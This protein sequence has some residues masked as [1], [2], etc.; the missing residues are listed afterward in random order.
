MR[1]VATIE[2]AADVATAASER[3]VL[4]DGTVA[5]VRALQRGE[6]PPITAWFDGLGLETRYARFLGTVDALA[7][8]LLASLADVD[9]CDHEALVAIGPDD[10]TMGIARYIR[11]RNPQQAEVAV[12]V[13]DR[14][15]NRGVAGTLL[16]QLADRAR[17]AGIHRLSATCLATNHAVIRTLS[18]VG[19][20]TT[21]PPLGGVVEVWIDLDRPTA[22][23]PS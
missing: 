17:A 15:R 8:D 22:N 21:G 1:P 4:R 7:H 10:S 19:P 5:V 2:T 9:H 20:T 14:W 12:A 23:V 6:E 18:R 16:A 11:M 13:V 3:V